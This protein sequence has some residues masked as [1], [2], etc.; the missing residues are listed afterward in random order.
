MSIKLVKASNE[1]Q[2]LI[3]DMLK[4]WIDYNNNH[5]EANTSPASIFKNDYHNFDYYI[6]NLD[7]KNPKPGLVE[8]STFFALDVE[9]NKMVG[10]IN[11]RHKLNDYLLNY[12]G[13]IGDGVRPSERRKCYA[14]KIIGLAL[15]ECQKL[16]IDKVLL[17]CDK[18]NIGSAKSI[19]NNGAILENEIVKDGKTIQRYWIEIGYSLILY[20][21]DF[22]VIQQFSLSFHL[23]YERWYCKAIPQL[24]DFYFLIFYF[25][26]TSKCI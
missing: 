17:V 22:L 15:K 5:S 9:R 7:L 4:E 25:I 26:N 10:A 23:S 2:D 16:N 1:Y 3:V 8:D 14:T 13:H 18:D 12:G 20:Y 19:K 6:N 24:F 21:L 11:I